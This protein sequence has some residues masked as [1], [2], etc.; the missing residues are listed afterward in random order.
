MTTFVLIWDA[1]DTGYPPANHR[2]DIAATAA[3]E[4]VRGRW[5]SGSRRSGTE[6][7]DRVYLLRQRTDRGIVASG[8]LTDGIIVAGPHWAGDPRRATYYLEVSW[9]RVL[10]VADRLPLDDLL[11]EVP[12]H[13]WNHIFASG[14]R[15]RPPS[16]AALDRLWVR[17]L[18]DLD[19]VSASGRR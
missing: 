3:G 10:P 11:H 4:T 16:D 12:R 15:V 19:D 2:A 14:Q 5:S 1:S 7:G 8:R 18:R 9:D 17:H 13:N 6:P